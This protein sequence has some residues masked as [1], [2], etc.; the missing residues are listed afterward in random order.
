MAC[1]NIMTGYPDGTFHPGANTTRGQSA[2]VMVLTEQWNIDVTGGPHFSDVIPG[3][4]FYD[5]VETAYNHHLVQGYP[6]GKF[7]VNNNV[8]R[9]QFCKMMVLAQGWAID[10]SGGPH[11]SD[12]PPGNPF[13]QYIETAYHHAVIGGYPDGKFRPNNNSTRAQIAKIVYLARN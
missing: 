3:S 9:G 10:T 1:Q 2:K 7:R 8:T 5:Y 13:Y 4:V 12:T 11:F 6:D